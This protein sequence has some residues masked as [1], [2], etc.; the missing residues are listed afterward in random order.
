MKNYPISQNSNGKSIG[1]Q[2]EFLLKSGKLLSTTSNDK[3]STLDNLYEIAS[4]PR[5]YDFNQQNLISNILDNLC[6]PAI[7]TQNFGDI[8]QEVKGQFIKYLDN[9]LG[10]K[11]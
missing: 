7:I 3:S 6:D 1:Q 9:E 4:T 2:L 5:V 8:P 11:S 10:D